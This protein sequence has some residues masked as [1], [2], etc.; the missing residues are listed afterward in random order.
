M[1]PFFVGLVGPAAEDGEE[2]KKI[3]YLAKKSNKNVESMNL[4]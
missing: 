1:R 3:Q 4:K 2:M